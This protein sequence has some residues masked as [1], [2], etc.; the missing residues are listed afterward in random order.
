MAVR[1]G[2][3]RG[4]RT[5]GRA[6]QALRGIAP[7]GLGA[8][9]AFSALPAAAQQGQPPNPLL[10][11]SF[12]SS[13]RASDN[14]DLSVDSPGNATILDNT[15]GLS[16]V[17]ETEVQ[18]LRFGLSGVARLA[19]LPRTGTDTRF[20]NQ[21]ASLEYARQGANSALRLNGRYNRADLAFFDPLSLVEQD[22]PI[23]D[24]DL[25]SLPDGYRETASLGASFETGL[26]D[27]LSFSLSANSRQRKFVGTDDSDLSLYDSRNTSL[28]AGI[29]AL[30]TP[31]TRLT[32]TGSSVWYRAED[33]EDTRRLNRS[34]SLGAVHETARALTLS[35]S[36]GYQVI[37]T[38][39]T[40]IFGQRVT[41]TDDG[42][43][44]A[45]GLSQELTNGTVGLNASHAITVNGGRST[46][47]AFRSLELP[48]G[49]LSFSLGLSSGD[50]GRNA[51]IGSIDYAQM[52]RYG[53]LRLGLARDVQT[54]NDD[55]DLEVTRARLGWTHDLTE[56]SGIDM[57]VTYAST[58]AVGDGATDRD[59]GRFQ[60]SYRHALTRDWDLSG[61]YAYTVSRREGRDDATEN[62]VFLTISR[63]FQV[64]P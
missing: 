16:Y 45:F 61:G 49:S 15:L 36:L 8:L 55:E 23:D 3:A 62:S 33:E 25:V 27:P 2:K 35:A 22:D 58:N 18:L 4:G 1:V 13:L 6:G 10:T 26:S 5:A 30:V 37:D 60:A 64:R 28:T 9:L 14:Y 46:L 40:D 48:E 43:T 54:S 57:N 50:T 56:L 34:L 42:A 47:S 52:L 7:A 29:G 20:D 51:V 59:R 39:E 63:Q 24:N 53:A 44:G 32:L 17:S 21:T 38:D 41:T 12:A 19:D 31:T 11:L